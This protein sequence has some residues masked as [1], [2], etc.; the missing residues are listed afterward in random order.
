[1]EPAPFG[2]KVTGLQ[3]HYGTARV[4]DRVDLEIKDGMIV[5]LVGASGAGKSTLLRQLLG[6]EK[7]TSGEIYIGHHNGQIER[8][9]KP[10]KNTGYVPQS[11][12]LFPNLTAIQNV[13]YGPMSGIWG[14]F[15]LIV[16][17]KVL[18]WVMM[19]WLPQFAKEMLH[20]YERMQEEAGDL[21]E[22]FGIDREHWDKFPT[23]LS[24]GQRQRIAVCRALIMKPEILYLDEP[25][26]GLDRERREDAQH[27][28]LEMAAENRAKRDRGE[29]PPYTV[30]LVTHEL[31]EAI[32]VADWVI[33]LSQ[34]WGDRE[35]GVGN[36]AG[37]RIIYSK[38][39]PLFTPE[40]DRPRGDHF[41]SEMDEITKVVLRGESDMPWDHYVD[42]LTVQSLPQKN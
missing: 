21:L 2:L 16:L 39:C 38:P 40:C 19:G 20:R 4:I 5:S 36:P 26:S 7:P 17:L 12:P 1:M 29:D 18:R 32:F 25:F 9:I 15:L 42:P 30:V 22:K 31:H 8:V 37:S 23:Q 10:G 41:E 28:L 3:V 11:Y 34:H 33:G 14:G 24:G 35:K 13:M 27:M 6:L